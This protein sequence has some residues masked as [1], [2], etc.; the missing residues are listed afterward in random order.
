MLAV[1]I[2]MIVH[3]SADIHP[4]EQVFVNSMTYFPYFVKSVRIVT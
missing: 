1:N 3:K 2:T 4:M